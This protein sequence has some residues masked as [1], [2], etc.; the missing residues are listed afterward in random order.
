VLGRSLDELPPQT[1]RLL[2]LLK[3][4]VSERCREKGLDRDQCLFTRRQVRE[5]SGWSNTQVKVHLDRLEDLEWI[6]PRRGARG[7]AFEYELLFDG[8]TEAGRPVLPG[9]IDAEGLKTYNCDGKFTG[10]ESGFAG[11]TDNNT[12]PK[13]GQNG[14]V[15]ESS[16]APEPAKQ[17]VSGPT[18]AATPENAQGAKEKSLRAFPQMAG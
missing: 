7:S 4:M 6:L 2:T 12:P 14:G 15:A 8:D 1:R 11:Q 9:L 13:R 10:S 3:T 16:N 5:C 17:G 18:A